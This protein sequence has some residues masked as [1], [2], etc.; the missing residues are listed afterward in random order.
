MS[1]RIYSLFG[2]LLAGHSLA[3]AQTLTSRASHMNYNYVYG[4]GADSHTG[5]DVFDQGD[6]LATDMDE[7]HYEGS[8]SGSLPGNPG[9]P[10]TAGVDIDLYQ[11]YYTI[12]PLNNLSTITSTNTTNLLANATGAGVSAAYSTTSGNSHQFEFTLARPRRYS[13][14]GTVSSSVNY[15]GEVTLRRWDGFTW[16]IWDTS[17]FGPGGLGPFGFNRTM[18]S[19]TYRFYTAAGINSTG[20]FHH[21]QAYGDLTFL[22]NHVTITGT[23]SLGDF[24]GNVAN[25]VVKVELVT[26]SGSILDSIPNVPLNGSGTF[27]CSTPIDGW[28]RVRVRGRTWLSKTWGQFLLAAGTNNVTLGGLKNGD[29]DHSGEVDAA[30]IDQVIAGFGGVANQPGYDI[31]ADL[32]GSGEVD[33][34]DIDVAIANFGETDG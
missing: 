33:A 26:N 10:Y 29:A 25:E 27:T 24:I 22:S 14:N 16:T 21:A 32:D 7:L 9:T 20:G 15:G 31:D 6:L 23:V 30:D 8:T 17:L 11:S 18:L 4:A 13:L 1:L 5:S 28:T 19:G 34:A 3:T 12:G 2:C